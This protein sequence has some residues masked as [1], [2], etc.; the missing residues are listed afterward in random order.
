MM[1][2]LV[3]CYLLVP[4]NIPHEP[5]PSWITER[6]LLEGSLQSESGINYDRKVPAELLKVVEIENPVAI[7]VDDF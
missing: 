4:G 7:F 5:I 2:Q 3:R 1:L 6:S